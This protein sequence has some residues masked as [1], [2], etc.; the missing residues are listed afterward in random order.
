[1]WRESGYSEKTFQTHTTLQRHLW[2]L[3]WVFDIGFGLGL[4][5]G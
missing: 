4:G 3:V 2:A 1:M 5:F